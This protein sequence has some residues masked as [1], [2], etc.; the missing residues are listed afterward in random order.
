MKTVNRKHQ[1]TPSAVTSVELLIAYLEHVIKVKKEHEFYP[2]FL[3]LE[4][5]AYV[6]D[7][8]LYVRLSKLNYWFNITQRIK[9]ANTTQ[10][11]CPPYNHY[12]IMLSEL[13][14]IKAKA[15]KPNS[16]HSFIRDRFTRTS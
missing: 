1:C 6:C 12:Q 3:P 13:L 11:H 14:K 9:E 15:E 8:M 16:F 2:S 5:I 7:V 10:G 4:E